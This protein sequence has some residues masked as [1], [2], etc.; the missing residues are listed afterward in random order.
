MD[1][2]PNQDSSGSR[3]RE[4]PE[5]EDHCTKLR[6]ISEPLTALQDGPCQ[7]QTSNIGASEAN[8]STPAAGDTLGVGNRGGQQVVKR[9][10]KGKKVKVL[11]KAV[12]P[13]V[14]RS[15]PVVKL[16]PGVLSSIHSVLGVEETVC[17]DHG[18]QV[19]VPIF[20]PHRYDK[21]MYAILQ[22]RNNTGQEDTMD[23]E[24]G[25]VFIGAL[26]CQFEGYLDLGGI[27]R[28]GD[29]NIHLFLVMDK[30]EAT[31]WQ[32]RIE[33]GK[34]VWCVPVKMDPLLAEVSV[35]DLEGML[36]GMAPHVRLFLP[37]DSSCGATNSL[38]LEFWATEKICNSSFASDY[39]Y[40]VASAKRVKPVLH[41]LVKTLHPSYSKEEQ[42][43]DAVQGL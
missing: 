42:N 13:K 6:R 4:H 41:R 5:P 9:R 39:S 20:H 26:S 25:C 21:D 18:N 22:S 15:I 1:M 43:K 19:V 11:V 24:A 16:S 31:K 33:V 34:G 36:L 23:G 40:S 12:K 29:T 2:N 14:Q 30:S 28:D 32:V 8:S 38:P 7:I 37:H 17:I 10:K 27:F 35:E 3:K